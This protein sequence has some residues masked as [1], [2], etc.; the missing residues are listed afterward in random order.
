MKF[1]LMIMAAMAIALN[2]S[3]QDNAKIDFPYDE[4][5]SYLIA[6]TYYR[7]SAE[8]IKAWTDSAD[9]VI[10][11]SFS[12]CGSLDEPADTNAFIIRRKDGKTFEPFGC[13]ELAYLRQ[14]ITPIGMIEPLVTR[15]NYGHIKDLLMLNAGNAF[16]LLPMIEF[17]TN[18][19]AKDEEVNAL[20]KKYGMTLTP[21]SG[22]GAERR[23]W[24]ASAQS[25]TANGIIR[26][27]EKL[28]AQKIIYSMQLMANG[29]PCPD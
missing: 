22:R 9:L 2:S 21:A 16:G 13:K 12:Y 25:D 19:G 27:A 7:N 20:M 15:N 23:T 28:A 6:L 10:K 11:R 4:H 29:M 18:E 5:P 26:I 24:Q 14:R 17:A 1:Y 8:K 3:A